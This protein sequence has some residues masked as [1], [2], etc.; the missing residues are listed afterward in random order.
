MGNG[1]MEKCPGNFVSFFINGKIQHV[2]KNSRGKKSNKKNPFIV[3]PYF[4][5]FYC[6]MC[7]SF[8]GFS[9]KVVVALSF[10]RLLATP[11]D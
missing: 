3:K 5:R 10:N 4:H 2:V 6:V 11:A 9:C 8:P 7:H 1:K